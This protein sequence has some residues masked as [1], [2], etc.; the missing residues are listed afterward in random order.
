MN[1]SMVL[2]LCKAY[3]LGYEYSR[4]MTNLFYFGNRLTPAMPFK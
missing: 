3:E 4:L 2:R 1:F